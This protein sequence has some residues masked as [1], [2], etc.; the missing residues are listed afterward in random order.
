MDFANKLQ[1]LRRNKWI[2]QE[3]PA[4]ALFVSRAAVSKWE[5][6]R[7]Y[8]NIFKQIRSKIYCRGYH[9]RIYGVYG[10]GTDHFRCALDHGYH[11]RYTDRPFPDRMVCLYDRQKSKVRL[12]L[13]FLHRADYPDLRKLQTVSVQMRTEVHIYPEVHPV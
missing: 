2:T 12:T 10:Y 11:R 5:S 8:P 9:G 6:G 1:E 4:Q 13:L 3:Q 7:G